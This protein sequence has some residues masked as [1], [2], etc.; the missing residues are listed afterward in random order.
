M[1]S[2]RRFLLVFVT[3]G[4]IT[5]LFAAALNAQTDDAEDLGRK[6]VQLYRA[7]KYAEAIPLAQR[8]LAI[9]EKALGPDHP[10]VAR[11]LNNLATV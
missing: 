3:A 11:S 1:I 6:V 9:N 2:V 10:D 8:V 4:A 7:G 5:I